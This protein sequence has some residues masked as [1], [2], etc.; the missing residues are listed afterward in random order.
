MLAF[1]A[2]KIVIGTQYIL[3]KKKNL[4]FFCWKTELTNWN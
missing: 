1:A 3:K 4:S 2:H